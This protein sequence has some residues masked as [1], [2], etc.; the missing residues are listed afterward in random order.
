MAQTVTHLTLPL[1][2][3]LAGMDLTPEE[4][5][6]AESL[7]LGPYRVTLPHDGFASPGSFC[8]AIEGD[9]GLG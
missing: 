8:V 1:A 4:T 9:N 7:S 6:F 2:E 5:E 3:V